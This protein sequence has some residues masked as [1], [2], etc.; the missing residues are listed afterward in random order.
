ML[1][2]FIFPMLTKFML[3]RNLYENHVRDVIY[4]NMHGSDVENMNMNV[5]HEYVPY[6][7]CVFLKSSNKYNNT[8]M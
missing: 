6:P 2:L 8:I 1:Y 7:V 4:Q 3:Q 5:C